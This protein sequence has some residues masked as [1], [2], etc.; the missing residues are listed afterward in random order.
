MA[1]KSTKAAAGSMSKAG[2]VKELLGK[3]VTAPKKISLAAK[4][5]YNM[6]ITPAYA[7]IIKSSSK[8]KRHLKPRGTKAMKATVAVA[9]SA[10]SSGMDLENA[11]LKLALRTGGIENA[12]KLLRKLQ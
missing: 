11:A 2:V 7:S 3:G 9:S 5:Q 1:K 10:S 4:E 6:D 12:I 8:K